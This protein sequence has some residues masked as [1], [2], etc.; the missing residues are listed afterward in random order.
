MPRVGI[1]PLKIGNALRINGLPRLARGS[2]PDGV[3]DSAVAWSTWAQRQLGFERLEQT[4]P[5]GS[6]IASNL[7]R[8]TRTEVPREFLDGRGKADAPF[9]RWAMG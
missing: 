2:H 8:E 1:E 9:S 6:R 5:K 3:A 4:N 7:S